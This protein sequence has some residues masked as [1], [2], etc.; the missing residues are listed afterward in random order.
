M[1]VLEAAALCTKRCACT[2]AC[3][4]RVSLAV[5]AAGRVRARLSY[6]PEEPYS[7][8]SSK[9]TPAP[10]PAMHTLEV[11]SVICS[12]RAK[13]THTHPQLATGQAPLARPSCC[14]PGV[15]GAAPWPHAAQTLGCPTHASLRPVHA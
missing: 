8:M 15:G 1:D 5:Y 10:V 11:S 6:A 9:K 2:L 12:A 4:T 3:R 7:P 13:H 14:A